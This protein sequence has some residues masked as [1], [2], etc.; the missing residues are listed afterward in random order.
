MF[1]SIGISIGAFF[2]DPLKFVGD[3]ANTI[4]EY[5]T[6]KM[7][8]EG[9]TAAEVEEELTKVGMLKGA[10]PVKVIIDAV[11]TTLELV[12]KNLPIILLGLVVIIALYYLRAFR[13]VK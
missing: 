11:G 3:P 6:K 2:S 4:I 12:S 9:K 10:G 13:A 1:K 8:T 5:Q 7:L